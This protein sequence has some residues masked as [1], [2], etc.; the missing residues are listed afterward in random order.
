LMDPNRLNYQLI[1]TVI[2]W[3]V[4][5][6]HSFP[7]TGSI[8]IFLPGMTEIST[9][10]GQLMGHPVLSPRTGKFVLIP[11][12]FSTHYWGTGWNFQETRARCP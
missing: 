8:L 10:H 1:E 9:L 3:I 5:G 6:E 4:A 11:T 7:T 2:T 12:T